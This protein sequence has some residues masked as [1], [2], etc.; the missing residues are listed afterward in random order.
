MVVLVSCMVAWSMAEVPAASARQLTKEAQNERMPI[1]WKNRSRKPEK[2]TS[3]TI[4][5]EHLHTFH[6]PKDQP[7]HALL[8]D[9]HIANF[10]F[11]SEA[12]FK[13][14]NYAPLEVPDTGIA[15]KTGEVAM[16]T[17]PSMLLPINEKP[18]AKK[19]VQRFIWE[20]SNTVKKRLKMYMQ[21]V[22]QAAFQVYLLGRIFAR[23]AGGPKPP[24]ILGEV[25][26]DGS[27]FNKEDTSKIWRLRCDHCVK[28]RCYIYHENNRQVRA[29]TKAMT[30]SSN[31][32]RECCRRRTTTRQYE[33]A[34]IYIYILCVWTEQ[35]KARPFNCDLQVPFSLFHFNL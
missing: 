16:P 18:T 12:D 5:T 21:I 35:E 25:P 27:F 11:P 31:S 28:G 32:S 3:G 33:Q 29:L 23:P 1:F 26:K 20:N 19:K 8:S 6:E 22:M 9:S 24:K 34:V 17:L 15:T 7:E 2:P 4:P 10:E 13:S 14:L 30:S